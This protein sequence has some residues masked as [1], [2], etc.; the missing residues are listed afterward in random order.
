MNYWRTFTVQTQCRRAS[1]RRD[2]I[3]E[4]QLNPVA[5]RKES[6]LQVNA[7]HRD[8][9]RRQDGSGA[10]RC[11]QSHGKQRTSARFAQT[12]SRRKCGS[13][14]ESDIFEE[15]ARSFDSVAAEPG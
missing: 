2:G 5:G 13:G 11:K 8:K 6:V 9:H 3:E 15:S 10:E 1:E 4:R 12:C 7:D 14:M